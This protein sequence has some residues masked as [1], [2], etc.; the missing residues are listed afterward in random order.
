MSKKWVCVVESTFTNGKIYHESDIAE[1]EETVQIN[2][3]WWLEKKF[4][5]Q[6]F[7]GSN[8]EYKKMIEEQKSLQKDMKSEI[9]PAKK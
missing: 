2:E 1:F 5:D 3:N 6:G 8:A 7:T 9:Q 4:Y